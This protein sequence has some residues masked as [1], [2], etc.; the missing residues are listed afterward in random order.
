MVSV[1]LLHEEELP[2]A[3]CLR[4]LWFSVKQDKCSQVAGIKIIIMETAANVF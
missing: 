2:Y 4:P 3:M 1:R